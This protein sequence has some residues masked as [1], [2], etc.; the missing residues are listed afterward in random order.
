MRIISVWLML[1]P[2][3]LMGAGTTVLMEENGGQFADEARL[4]G[5]W[6]NT[7]IGFG[8]RITY[9]N[10]GARMWMEF[11]GAR[12]VMP[13]PEERQDVRIRAYRGSDP[14]RWKQ[15]LKAYAAVRYPQLY[16]GI[17]AVFHA[18][19][20]AL[21]Y[22]FLVAPGADPRAIHF[23]L[24]EARRVR[25]DESG[26]LV[27]E[28]S[29][30]EALRHQRPVAYQVVRGKR[31]TVPAYFQLRG[32][33][34]SFV[35]ARYDASQPLVIDPVLRFSTVMQSPFS[36]IASDAASNSYVAS[37]IS[38]G[39]QTDFDLLYWKFDPQGKL[40][41]KV[42]LGG[43]GWEEPGRMVAD[44]NG[45]LFLTGTSNSSD[46]PVSANPC[47]GPKTDLILTKLGPTGAILASRCLGG[48]RAESVA[49]IG[50]DNAGAVY[51]GGTTES[52]DFPTTAGVFQTQPRMPDSK[53]GF[54]AK[55]DPASLVLSLSTLLGGFGDTQVHD[56]A[57]E[58]GGAVV[59][60]GAAWQ[61]GFRVTPGALLVT[62]PA[63]P[64]ASIVPFVTRVAAGLAS[65]SY[66]TFLPVELQ[67]Q[68]RLRIG[69]DGQGQT[70][71]A[72]PGST[73]T[74]RLMKL[75]GSGSQLI[76]DK[77]LPNRGG[78][79]SLEVDAAGNLLLISADTNAFAL[80][81]DTLQ[82][83]SADVVILKLDPAANNVLY[84]SAVT[85]T[86]AMAKFGP[87][88]EI[89]VAT[90]LGGNALPERFPVTAGATSEAPN[91]A[92][93]QAREFF[94]L[95][96]IV[97]G[98]AVC[99][100][101][102]EVSE[103]NIPTTGTTLTVGFTAP[104]NCTWAASVWQYSSGWI[105]LEGK[106]YGT[107]NGGVMFTAKPL[108]APETGRRA[109]ISVAPSAAVTLTQGIAPSCQ[110]VLPGSV[111]ASGAAATREF[112]FSLPDVCAWT[113]SSDSAWLRIVS[114][115]SGMGSAMLY[116]ATD[117]NYAAT[118]R[119]GTITINTQSV[120]VTQSPC[121]FNFGGSLLDSRASVQPMP[122]AAE[123][124]C[125][126]TLTSNAPWVRLNIDSTTVR[127]GPMTVLAEI[128]ENLTSTA[129]T[130]TFTL[131]GRSFSIQQAANS[132]FPSATVTQS[133]FASA[134][135]NGSFTVVVPSGC[136]ALG[137]I[138]S[139]GAVTSTS[140][141]QAGSGVFQ[142]TVAANTGPLPRA[143]RATGGVLGMHV[144]MPLLQEGVNPAAPFD[145]V[146]VGHPFFS[147]VAILKDRQV[148]RGCTFDARR[149][150]PAEI[151]TRAEM[152]TFLARALQLSGGGVP[153]FEDVPPTHPHFTGIQA[154]RSAGITFGC[155]TLP[156]RYCPD[157][158]LTRGQMAALII[159]AISG[160]NVSYTNNPSFQDVTTA[161]AFFRHV[162]RMKELGITLGCTTTT[163]C[164]DSLTT[165]G[166][167]AAFLVR[168]FLSN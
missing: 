162:Q 123:L 140:V 119:Q 48:V 60:A 118:P 155:A 18:R 129:R 105:T 160:D 13:I 43:L 57:L 73:E 14:R 32:D 81:A 147:H 114:A 103:L 158:P 132:C 130:G 80:T 134:G 58:P 56:M 95:Y 44:A 10:Q 144:Y 146:P 107:G 83:R 22:D 151:V 52:G 71:V 167:M 29:N 40:L 128:D 120:T 156:D 138:A 39:G 59:L 79:E 145:D 19:G 21:E 26:D 157:Q 50:I 164:P 141:P 1:L 113:V 98:S 112:Y 96:R 126:W 85:G 84:A 122:V 143:F 102:P 100:P 110:V 88:S 6:G 23:R 61:S 5:F 90:S 38:V 24:R 109:V 139:P 49:G 7:S 11:R 9:R 121:Q 74:V 34:V 133:T 86:N 65:L 28:F 131:G 55:F 91:I 104:A 161:Y 76:F 68:Q 87:G 148:T 46:Y 27:A 45:N 77:T 165:R 2:G 135:G 124:G 70:V 69:S 116:F 67:N 72:M 93:P 63:S 166:E 62:G 12:A 35:V 92:L 54:V 25:L 66:S 78:S 3:M 159:R 89:L 149:Y 53:C 117:A 31:R 51:V 136:N 4:G 94:G 168:A 15:E 97:L 17:D 8:E 125:P 30:G 41:Y 47:R 111:N 82:G 20:G 163:Y 152:A 142:F 42:Y 153:Y 150:C 101:A 154:I 64:Q 16:P 108:T 127:N 99:T 33:T 37:R 115:V 106:S 137:S 75:N 36:Q